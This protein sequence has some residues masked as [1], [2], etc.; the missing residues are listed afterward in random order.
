AAD[1]GHDVDDDERRTDVLQ[2]DAVAVAEE[3]RAPE[4]V[5]RPDRVGEEL[6]EGESPGLRVGEQQP[7]A[8]AAG[9]LGRVAVDV[10][11]LARRDAGDSVTPS[12]PRATPKLSAPRANPWSIA[13][14]LHAAS[15]M[16]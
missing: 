14:P 11:E 4:Q 15:A 7:P 1:V 9:G 2:V 12:R 10:R 6:A 16:A 5:E 3:R 8:H 13:A